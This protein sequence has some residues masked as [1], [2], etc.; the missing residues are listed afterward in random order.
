MLNQLRQSV[1]GSVMMIMIIMT[2]SAPFAVGQTDLPPAA[3]ATAPK[4]WPREIQKGD[5]TIV[6]QRP[7]SP[8]VAHCAFAPRRL[9]AASCYT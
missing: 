7:Q 2:V 1:F 6:L 8:P 9:W 3:E 4:E 5:A